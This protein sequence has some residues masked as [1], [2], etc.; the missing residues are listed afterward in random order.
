LVWLFQSLFTLPS[1]SQGLGSALKNEEPITDIFWTILID[2]SCSHYLQQQPQNRADY[3]NIGKMM[4][5]RYPKIKSEGK[6]PWVRKTLKYKTSTEIYSKQ[7]IKYPISA[8]ICS[9]LFIDQVHYLPEQKNSEGTNTSEPA[10][11][12]TKS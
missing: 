12:C 8:Y 6:K 4:F 11:S 2:E 9:L 5:L 1:F 3:A 7:M 10:G